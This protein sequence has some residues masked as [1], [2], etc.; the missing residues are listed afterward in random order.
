M[1]V[2]LHL[3][4]ST[5][6]NAKC[7]FCMYATSEQKRITMDWPLSEKII[8][9]AATIPLIEGIAFSGLSE[10]LT[11]K[12]LERRMALAAELRPD[13]YLELYT[14]GTLLSPTRFE[15]LKAA[16]LTC[17]SISLNAVTSAQH[18]K[19]MGLK[20]KFQTVCENARYAKAN[21]VG[22]NMRLLVKA[23][24]SYDHFTMADANIFRA[25]WGVIDEGDGV[26][27]V[28][29]EGNWAGENRLIKER[30]TDFN[31]T[32]N[33]ALNQISVHPDGR[34]GLCC[35]DPLVKH[36]MGDLKTQTIREIYNAAGYLEF[37][38]WHRDNVAAKH[39][40]CAKCARI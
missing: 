28:V 21:R 12:L 17:L 13:W 33:R 14:N 25:V 18:E 22:S 10:P 37:R 27:A 24:V 4:T 36:Q 40:M 6:C 16:G 19:I 2:Q 8:R 30:T 20:N 39:P 5:T 23:V 1:A 38:E 35:L 26:G 15:S 9:D 11:D 34:V 7:H 29:M 31:A 32:C 3:S